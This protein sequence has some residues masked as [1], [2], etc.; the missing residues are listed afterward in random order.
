MLFVKCAT[1]VLAHGRDTRER[2]FAF[3]P[4]SKAKHAHANDNTQRP[5]SASRNVCGVSGDAV[6]TEENERVSCAAFRAGVAFL[7]SH[8]CL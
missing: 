2:T 8:G 5:P 1:H 3:P 7:L 4:A 6:R